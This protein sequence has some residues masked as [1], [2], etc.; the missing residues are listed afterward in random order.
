MNAPLMNQPISLEDQL[1]Q[2]ISNLGIDGVMQKYHVGRK[3]V[4]K[5]CIELGI[6]I[7]RR[8]RPP[9]DIPTEFVDYVQRYL[10]KANVGY[11]RLAGVARRDPTAPPG[12]TEWMIRRIYESLDLYIRLQEYVPPGDEHSLMF[13][14][15]YAGQAWH[16]D[17]HELDAL[18][19]EN[20]K[21]YL[22]G[23]IDDRTRR[24][25]HHEILPNKTSLLAMNALVNAL[26]KNPR[27]KMV[28]SDNG[29]EFVGSPFSNKLQ[30]LGIELHRT[31]PYTPQENGKIERWWE[32]LERSKKLPLREP[33]LSYLVQQYN[34]TWEHRSV[35]KLLNQKV[36][37]SEAWNQMEKYNGQLDANFEY[38]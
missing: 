2:E 34:D 30:E 9:R 4:H 13:V 6:E 17:L 11:Q 19:G 35:S 5:L 36:T 23:F 33:Y 18:P 32:T 22:I 12:L 8:G 28:I 31:H 38:F 37:P 15:K 20:G 27:P 1:R 29:L 7:P 3:M 14:A 24:I 21:L 26:S 10:Q 25:M 16:T